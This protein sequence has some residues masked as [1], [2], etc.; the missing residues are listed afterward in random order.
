MARLRNLF[1]TKWG[2]VS[3]GAFIGIFAALLQKWGNPG[4][5]GICVACFE[6]D[7]AGAVGLQRAAVVQ[8][9]RPEI[10][11]FVM[12]SVNLLPQSGRHH[13]VPPRGARSWESPFAFRFSYSRSRFP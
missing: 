3:V 8:Y 2:I 10:I 13:E 4:N 11:G 7:I 5:M 9:I 6:R 1:A 12:G